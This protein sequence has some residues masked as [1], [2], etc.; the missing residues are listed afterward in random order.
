MK[1]QLFFALLYLFYSV[2]TYAVDAVEKLDYQEEISVELGLI[3]TSGDTE[4]KNINA[5]LNVQQEWQKLRNEVELKYRYASQDDDTSSE[6][7]LISEE[8]NYLFGDRN[9]FLFGR[10]LHEED[11]FSG[12]DY[13]TA[14]SI[15]YGCRYIDTEVHRL[16]LKLGSGY[17]FVET[18][19]TYSEQL[20]LSDEAIVEAT[21]LYKVNLSEAATL[22]EN[23]SVEFGS[24]VTISKSETSL[25]TR[26]N[27]KLAI[28]LS[29]EM[30]YTDKVPE[31]KNQ[32]NTETLITLT[33]EI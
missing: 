3:I 32:F 13:Q 16:D 23:F 11:K 21:T 18:I 20:E 7:Y 19:Q 1:Y 29:L 2:C 28:K 14:I 17:R 26:I 10:I 24:D 6:N 5:Q 22:E 4:A 25:K 8:L 31:G 27:D 30:K 33:Y 12:F 9:R 15:G